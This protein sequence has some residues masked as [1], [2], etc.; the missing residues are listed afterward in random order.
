MLSHANAFPRILQG[1]FSFK[2]RTSARSRPRRCRPGCA[3][4]GCRAGSGHGTARPGPAPLGSTGSFPAGS[5]PADDRA[6]GA[7]KPLRSAPNVGAAAT[8]AGQD[9]R[10]DPA[11]IPCR[12]RSQ[13]P[14]VLLSIPGDAR[15]PWITRIPSAP[16]Q[17]AGHHAGL[18]FLSIPAPLSRFLPQRW[19][20]HCSGSLGWALKGFSLPSQTLANISSGGAALWP[21]GTD[22][23]P[24]HCVPVPALGLIPVYSHRLMGLRHGF[25]P[26]PSWKWEAHND[27][28]VHLLLLTFPRHWLSFLLCQDNP[29]LPVCLKGP[30]GA[31]R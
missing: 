10:V 12:G 7:L 30:A 4:R 15:T 29:A 27:K 31:Q 20:W 26:L 11:G 17:T 16:A 28:S 2:R 9:S 18:C 5:K 6:N 14:T 1:G 19:S 24:C 8:A 13:P 21:C 3:R 23:Q 22:E 25:I